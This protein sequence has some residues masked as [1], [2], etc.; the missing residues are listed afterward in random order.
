MITDCQ[1]RFNYSMAVETLTLTDWWDGKE[2]HLIDPWSTNTINRFRPDVA[3]LY[4]AIAIPGD[5][6]VSICTGNPGMPYW[7]TL[8]VDQT[9][10]YVNLT[11]GKRPEDLVFALKEDAS[12]AMWKTVEVMGK[13]PPENLANLWEE[14]ENNYWKAVWWL[15]R[16][17]LEKT[18]SEK[19]AAWGGA[20]TNF[21]EVIA[22][23]EKIR[24][25]CGPRPTN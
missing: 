4:S 22:Q 15:D 6:K 9:G 20:A 5:H 12:A 13:Q 18:S 19:A 8:A 7:G 17:L 16:A 3:T 10:T 11:L 14:A 2:W 24:E 21:A 1:G 25:L 23:A